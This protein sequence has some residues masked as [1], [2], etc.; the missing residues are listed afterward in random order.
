MLARDALPLTSPPLPAVEWASLLSTPEAVIDR[1]PPVAC[2]TTLPPPSTTPSPSVACVVVSELALAT[3][4]PAET[5]P[6][7]S[8]LAEALWLLLSTAAMVTSPS[9]NVTAFPTLAVTVLVLV[10]V[11]ADALAPARMPP[12][13]PLVVAVVVGDALACT[14]RSPDV[15]LPVTPNTTLLP[16][17]AVTVASMLPSATFAPMPRPPAMLM[18]S[19][20]ALA[21]GDAEAVTHTPE[22][23]WPGSTEH[24]VVPVFVKCTPSPTFAV[25]VESSLALETTALMAAVMPPWPMTPSALTRP[26]SLACTFTNG[27][28][29]MLAS[30][31]IRACTVLLRKASSM[32]APATTPPTLMPLRL[33]LPAT[34]EL[35]SV[36]WI[37][38]PSLIDPSSAWMVPLLV[39]LTVLSTWLIA[40]AAPMPTAPPTPA[41]ALV[42]AAG[43]LSS[44]A[45]AR[46]D[47]PPLALIVL[48]A[49]TVEATFVLSVV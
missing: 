35:A 27:M 21:V 32:T 14:C 4:A 47:T 23:D 36:A 41:K 49:S 33:P 7:L 31:P 26:L 45:P 22:P 48:D 43:S 30:S 10:A 15:L 37:V 19:A 2:A 1:L 25:T 40:T 28:P 11:D 20:D 44:P 6:P 34:T 3:E 46:M 9:G 13:P 29:L 38:N 16:T 8:P 17:W 42:F 12:A 5:M 39:A 24:C 18:P